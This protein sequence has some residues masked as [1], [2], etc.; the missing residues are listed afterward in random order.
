M[1][2][3][4]FRNYSILEWK[5]ALKIFRVNLIVMSKEKLKIRKFWGET[6]PQTRVREGKKENYDR[7]SNKKF[8][9]KSLEEEDF[10]LDLEYKL[11]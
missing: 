2:W 4:N 3:N 11:N 9:E 6:C 8:I 10:D 1:W 5:R 7:H